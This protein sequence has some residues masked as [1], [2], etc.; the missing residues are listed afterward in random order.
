LQKRF[1]ITGLG[2]A[3][4]D[5]TEAGYSPAGMRLFEQNPGG[6][7]TNM[8]TAAARLGLK[9]AFIGKVGADMHGRFLKETLERDG[10]DVSGMIV[11]EDEFTTLAFVS[12]DPKSGE[13]DFSFA[14]KPG[15]DTCLS[16]DELKLDIIE[17]TGVFHVGSLSLTDEPARTATYMA[18]KKAKE[19]GAII[20][21]DPNYRPP[22]WNSR[23]DAVLAMRG[24]L[25]FVDIMKLSDEEALLLTGRSESSDG[26]GDEHGSKRLNRVEKA[27][28]EL[29]SRGIDIV[30]VTLGKDGALVCKGGKCRSVSAYKAPVVVDATGAGDSFWGAF[31]YRMLISGKSLDII[32]LDDIASYAKFANAAA[33][34]CVSR[35]GGIPAMP[36]LRE[37]DGECGAF[38]KCLTK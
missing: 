2:E 31:F 37:V 30:A 16:A 33:S 21:Y 18:V 15:A 7:I 34:I 26:D 23:E 3:L 20:S 36:T 6:A 32:D 11:T 4:I 9:T 10:I 27:A 8:L 5:F 24:L 14:R 38:S 12:L 29:N 19:A 1:D 13:R 28:I 17:N 25:P 35:R 22:L